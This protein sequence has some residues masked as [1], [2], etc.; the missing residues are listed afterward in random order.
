MTR[1]LTIALAT[2]LAA[3]GLA[4]DAPAQSERAAGLALLERARAA[5]GGA[6]RLAAIKGLQLREPDRVTTVLWPDVYR[7]DLLAPFG[8]IRTVF[9]GRDLWQVWPEG[10]P[11][12]AAP[13]VSAARTGA[14]STLARLALTY[15]TEP[16]GLG[17]VTPTAAGKQTW[18][19]VSGD[20]VRLVPASAPREAAWGIILGSDMLPTAVLSPSRPT[21]SGPPTGYTVT[22]LLDYRDVSGV[23]FPFQTQAYRVDAS[24]RVTQSLASTRIE[25]LVV[26]PSI[27]KAELVAR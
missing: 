7:I 5:R 3:S 12:P 18:G 13:D 17:R 4:A 22:V 11:P 14:R 20:V 15:L 27:S 6:A 26:N 2:V 1:R 25:S 16:A 23:Q 21:S 10:V 19:P 24:G 8:T 9:D